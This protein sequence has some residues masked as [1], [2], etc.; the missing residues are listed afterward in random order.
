MESL[1]P[2]LKKKAALSKEAQ[3]PNIEMAKNIGQSAPKVF[4]KTG[5]LFDAW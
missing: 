4:L 3:K 5:T 2:E 1:W